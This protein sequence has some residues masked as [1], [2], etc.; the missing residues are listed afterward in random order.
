MGL[1]GKL[2][3]EI[4]IKSSAEAYFKR[5]KDEL[6]HLPDAASNVHG[7]EVHEGDFKTHGSIKSWTYTLDGRTEVFKER[8]EIDEKNMSVSMV[9]VDG[10]I[11]Q[12]YKS[13]KLIYKVIPKT[14]NEPPA[15]RV[16]LDYEKHKET[17]ADPHKEME[18]MISM[19]KDIDKHLL[20]Q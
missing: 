1:R 20:G 5:L 19:M 7:V 13:Y 4:E 14:G 2:A 9:A 10:H 18:F 11:L 16:T 17:D 3:A 6:H 12:R 15:V 8:F